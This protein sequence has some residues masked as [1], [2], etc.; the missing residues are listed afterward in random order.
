MFERFSHLEPFLL[1]SL[2]NLGR[3]EEISV[4]IDEFHFTTKVLPR[5]EVIDLSFQSFLFEVWY[6]PPHM[7]KHFEVTGRGIVKCCTSTT[8]TAMIAV[9]EA[10]LFEE[11]KERT[12]F[13]RL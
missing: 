2:K 12:M 8:T 13:G 1:S 3:S 10:E 11:G 9:R 6:W 4:F 5:D 7:S